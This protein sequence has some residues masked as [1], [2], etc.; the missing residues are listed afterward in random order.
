M[1]PRAQ[2]EPTLQFGLMKLS[3]PMPISKVSPAGHKMLKMPMPTAVFLCGPWE[4]QGERHTILTAKS[5]RKRKKEEKGEGRGL[6]VGWFCGLLVFW[7]WRVDTAKPRANFR[8]H[9]H[10]QSF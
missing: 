1:Q 7:T 9:S 10:H 5:R 8:R 2:A 3:L 6:F 4:L